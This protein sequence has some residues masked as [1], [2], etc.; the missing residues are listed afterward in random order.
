MSLAKPGGQ[1]QD[2]FQNSLG[3]RNE[4]KGPGEFNGYL[5]PAK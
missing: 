4:G 3:R 5:F 2:F 1:D